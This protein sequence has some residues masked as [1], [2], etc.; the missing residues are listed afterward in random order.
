V[1]G[2]AQELFGH[3]KCL[4]KLHTN[5]AREEN[6]GRERFPPDRPPGQNIP[7]FFT[8]VSFDKFFAQIEPGRKSLPKSV[9]NIHI[10][11]KKN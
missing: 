5:W 1:F 10:Y 7:D 6:L 9:P 2:L 4:L 3:F 8:K 11:A